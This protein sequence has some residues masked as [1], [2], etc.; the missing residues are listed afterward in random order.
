MVDGPF[1]LDEAIEVA[2]SGR[3][4]QWG[5]ACNQKIGEHMGIGMSD[6]PRVRRTYVVRTS[7]RSPAEAEFG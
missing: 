1:T 3:R 2:L 7:V 4:C 5:S 6:S